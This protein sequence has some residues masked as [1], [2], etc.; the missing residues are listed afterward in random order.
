MTSAAVA[1]GAHSQKKSAIIRAASDLF[2]SRGYDG[3]SMDMIA[4]A[5]G[6]SR[7]TIYNQ[8][9]NKDALFRA[10]AAELVGE[11][12]APLGKAADGVTTRARLLSFAE[13]VLD[14]V[15]R[16]RTLALHRLALTET[17]RFPDFG[18][19]VYE[20]GPARVLD[21]LASYLREEER[22]GY[23]QLSDA[24]VAAGQFFAIVTRDSEFKALL[25]VEGKLGTQELKRRA[26]AGV[27]AFM[28]AYGTCGSSVRALPR[29]DLKM[30]RKP[31]RRPA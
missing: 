31:L 23:L 2:A 13:H 7:Q 29:S 17:T 8:F 3:T 18:R 4:E 5:A 1:S 20:A 26:E 30:K 16:P 6:V 24:H 9:E 19:A 28:R 14:M 21:V 22:Q 12:L 11:L 10:L 15:L 25:G 27:D